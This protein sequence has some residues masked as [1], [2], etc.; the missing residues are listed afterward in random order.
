MTPNAFAP[1]EQSPYLAPAPDDVPQIAAYPEVEIP[2]TP[3]PV[4]GLAVE[5]STPGVLPVAV[6]RTVAMILSF[7]ER[8]RPRHH[9]EMLHAARR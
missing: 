6:P 3:L 5:P 8:W 7:S 9:Q 4:A 2:F 1:P